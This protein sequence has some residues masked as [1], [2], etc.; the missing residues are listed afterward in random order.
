MEV[1]GS[2]YSKMQ[3]I[4]KSSLERLRGVPRV[5]ITQNSF[6]VETFSIHIANTLG[7]KNNKK[8]GILFDLSYEIV[9]VSCIFVHFMFIILT[10]LS[11][12]GLSIVTKHLSYS[13]ASVYCQ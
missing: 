5:K 4:P 6:D 11:F 2:C 12:K 7:K 8:Y 1:H 9:Y 3:I 13:N 10:C